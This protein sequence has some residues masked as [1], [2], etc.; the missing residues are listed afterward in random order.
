MKNIRLILFALVAFT[1]VTSCIVDDEPDNSYAEG[2]Y[3]VGFDKKIAA[4]TYFAD[5]GVVLNQYPV[6][7]LGGMDG[8]LPSQ[9][10]VINYTID[11]S[12]SAVEGQEFDFVSNTGT[13]ILPAGAT[14]VNFPLNVNT[15]NF[16][17]NLPTTLVL[18]LVSTSTDGT[19]V[20]ASKNTLTI[21][22]VGCQADLDE[23]QYNVKVTNDA[24]GVVSDRG[25]EI[26]YSEGINLFRTQ[27]TATLGGNG[28]PVDMQ[29]FD[30][31]VLCGDINIPS[32]GLFQGAFANN[33]LV[34][35]EATRV[36][37][38]GNFVLK[39]SANYG[40]ATGVLNFTAVYTRL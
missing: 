8:S 1:T 30:F 29:G 19:V 36:D 37:E 38:D 2:S 16:D 26:I 9:D 20:A 4:V 33:E 35:T 10:I 24:S 23:Y 27:S 13:L 3:F 7:L 17:A 14:F 31:V 39:Y 28:Q 11:P 12:S 40:G 22:F 21:T 5:E 32:Q 25:T 6:K 15:G 34:G 18:K